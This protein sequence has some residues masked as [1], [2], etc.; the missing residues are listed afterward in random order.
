[1]EKLFLK[2]EQV[3][4]T[5]SQ[6]EELLKLGLNKNTADAM[7]Y[8]W[9]ASDY[10]SQH[11][12]RYKTDTVWTEETNITDECIPAWTLPRLLKLIP[13]DFEYNNYRLYLGFVD[14]NS[15]GY[16]YDNT[17]NLPRSVFISFRANNIFQSCIDCLNWTI[18]NECIDTIYLKLS[19][20]NFPN[21]ES[22]AIYKCGLAPCNTC[23]K[24]PPTG[25]SIDNCRNNNPCKKY[26]EWY[27][28][29]QFR[30][31][32]YKNKVK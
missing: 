12:W 24:H 8:Y 17:N 3:V 14:N 26:F 21:A 4:T 1:M 2:P 29:Y 6:S 25:D 15:L 27:G 30:Q 13:K 9:D 5:K 31:L 28:E 22:Y 10:S 19:Y 23:T 20:N 16:S 7:H 18:K 11:E 32:E